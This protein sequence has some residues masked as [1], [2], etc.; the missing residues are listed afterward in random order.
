M[1]ECEQIKALNENRHD[2]RIVFV[3]LKLNTL[4]KMHPFCAF[5][6]MQ[7]RTK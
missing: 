7:E 5:P 6:R 3:T 4:T 1:K 2:N